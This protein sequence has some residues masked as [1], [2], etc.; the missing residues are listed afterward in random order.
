MTGIPSRY[1]SL[2]EGFSE[3]NPSTGV[4]ADEDDGDSDV[5]D[6]SDIMYAIEEVES[7]EENDSSRGATRRRTQVQHF[8]REVEVMSTPTHV[9][10]AKLLYYCRDGEE[11]ILVYEWMEKKSLNLYIFG[12][13]GL[14]SSLSWAQRRE[15]IR[16]VAVGVE[17]LH[18]RGFI[19]RDLK[20][21]NILVSDV[22]SKDSG[23]RH[24]EA[25]Y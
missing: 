3:H 20:P 7:A 16:G 24:R 5:H 6:G 21:A 13:D 23:L 1:A 10:L 22:G 15:I 17:F 9:N 19:H 4:L 12:E 11:W 25:V 14:R 2:E 8:S 18:G